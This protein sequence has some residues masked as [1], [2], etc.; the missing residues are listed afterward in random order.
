MTMSHSAHRKHAI[1]VEQKENT[2]S[3]EVGPRKKVDLELLKQ[4]LRHRSIRSFMDGDAANVWQDIELRIDPDHFCISCQISSINKRGRSKT[5]FKPKGP[6]KWVL[7][8][9]FQQ[10]PP[11]GILIIF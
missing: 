4:R 5:P 8:T 11:K 3:K 10:P 9:L 1:L 2:K 6:F 7:W